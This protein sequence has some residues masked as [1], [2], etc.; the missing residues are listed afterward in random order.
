MKSQKI[1][2]F[3]LESDQQRPELIN[4]GEGALNRKASFVHPTVK[5][6]FPSTFRGF[7]VACVFINVRNHPHIPEQLARRTGIEATIRVEEGTFIGDLNPFQGSKHRFQGLR[8][9]IRVIMIA[10]QNISRRKDVSIVIDQRQD[11]TGFRL[12]SALIGYA[13]AP[14]FATLWLPSRWSADK[15]SSPRAEIRLA[16]KRRWRLP[17]ALHLRK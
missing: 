11:V 10:C 9:V 7:P 1:S 6:S 8:Q 17:S 12:L 16:S 13:F 5:V 4:P 3:A 15:F 2:I 14:F